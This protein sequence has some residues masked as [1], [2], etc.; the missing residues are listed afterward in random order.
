MLVMLLSLAA[1]KDNEVGKTDGTENENAN[2]GGDQTDNNID[3][4]ET[5]EENGSSD[6]DEEKKPDEFF[7][8]AE[9]SGRGEASCNP[10]FTEKQ[11]QNQKIKGASIMS[12]IEEA[13]KDFSKSSFTIPAGDYGFEMNKYFQGMGVPYGFGLY[14]IQR[15]DDNPFTIYAEG[16][17]FWMEN[18]GLPSASA[19]YTFVLANCSNIKVVGLT[20]D[21]YTS[22]DIEGTVTKIDRKNNRI[23]IQLTNSSMEVND[24]VIAK[25]LAGAQCRIVPYKADGRFIAPLY[26]IDPNGWGPAP[27]L[28]AGFEST[29]NEGE[30]WITFANDVLIR[31][32]TDTSWKTTY[33]EDG[34]IVEGDVI[35]FLYGNVLTAL[36]NSKQITI[37]GLSQY[38]TKGMFAEDG[39]Y[40]AHVWKDCYFGPRPGSSKV[41]ASGEYMLCG[42]RIGTTLDNVTIMSSSDDAINIHGYLSLISGINGNTLSINYLKDGAMAGDVAEFYDADGNLVL[43]RTLAEDVT[44]GVFQHRT[45]KFTE[46]VSQEYKNCTI[47]WPSLECD[48]WTIKNCNFTNNYQRILVQSGSGTFE[49]NKVYNMGA[50]LALGSIFHVP[51]IY[52]GGILGTIT[53]KNNVFVNSSNSPR[54]ALVGI[55]QSYNFKGKMLAVNIEV[56][57]NLFI[58]CGYVFSARNCERATFKN[59]VV[60]QPKSSGLEAED[61]MDVV[62][63]CEYVNDL[64]IEGNSLYCTN[65]TD[66]DSEGTNKNYSI[67]LKLVRQA[68]KYAENSDKS[69]SEIIEIIKA[70]L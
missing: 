35:S 66:G 53:V 24:I 26:R 9:K 49:N 45:V 30:Y 56:E 52:E 69:A 18:T 61:F 64:E 13:A 22:N 51:S 12:E 57:D 7:D 63:N 50:N 28:V 68:K 65:C 27:M 21:E 17:T 19:S 39:G 32:I 55:D 23:A 47:R 2:I 6:T 5:D 31:T 16:V 10:D 67:T 36:H 25:A 29:G 40:G 14:G 44:A 43:K 38:C 70:H 58:N 15:P 4:G 11:I 48:G 8:V 33:G 59:N 41:A 60:I 1:C 42:T 54:T 37:E 46:S 34:Y 62:Q 20:I 3:N